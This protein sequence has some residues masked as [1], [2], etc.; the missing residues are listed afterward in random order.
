MI[1]PQEPQRVDPPP[2][3]GRGAGRTNSRLADA[4]GPC[5]TEESI[6]AALGH[7]AEEIATLI[8]GDYLLALTTSDGSVVFP[9]FQLDHGRTVQALP[10]VLRMLR[11]GINDPWTWALWL[12]STPPFSADDHD[13][14]G[15]SRMAQLIAGDVDGVVLAAYRAA[16]S[17]RSR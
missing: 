14:P 6:G 4:I 2:R 3:V 8:Q 1:E 17:W 11:K 5:F 12:N 9:A 15:T 7:S 16:Q 13:A 10:P